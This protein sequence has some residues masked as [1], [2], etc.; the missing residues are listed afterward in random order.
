M[1]LLDYLV[2]AGLG[3]W[4]VAAVRGMRRGKGGCCGSCANCGGCA[5]CVVK[6]TD[7]R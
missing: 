7:K 4:L 2:L 5:K 1:S 6:T 3:L